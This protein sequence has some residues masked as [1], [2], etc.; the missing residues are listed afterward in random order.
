M[1]N[2]AV[3]QLQLSSTDTRVLQGSFL[4]GL[5]GKEAAYTISDQS[6]LSH[7]LALY[8]KVPLPRSLASEWPEGAVR[9]GHHFENG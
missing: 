8:T 2:A 7:E 1:T 5:P 6:R 4:P 3:H 9:T